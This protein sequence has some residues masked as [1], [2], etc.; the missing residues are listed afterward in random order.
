MEQSAGE[1]PIAGLRIEREQSTSTD[2][3]PVAARDLFIGQAI[4]VVSCWLD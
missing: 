3:I 1:T 4:K 2:P